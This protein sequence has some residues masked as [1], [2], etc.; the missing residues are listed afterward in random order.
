MKKLSLPLDKFQTILCCPLCKS[1]LEFDE[2]LIRCK[3]CKAEFRIKDGI[4]VFVKDEN[5]TSHSKKQIEIFDE[6]YKRGPV[7]SIWMNRYIDR[8]F[9]NITFKADSLTLDIA[10]GNG[11]I[12]LAL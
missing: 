3:Q 6:T 10:S 2:K 11:Y 5:L 8:L 7:C 4:F 9:K 1:S 12:P